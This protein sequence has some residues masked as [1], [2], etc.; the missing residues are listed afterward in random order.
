MDWS[1]ASGYADY[2]TVQA[3]Q[4]GGVFY[5][6]TLKWQIQTQSFEIVSISEN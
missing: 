3:V 5:T 1:L 6:V 4:V 2:I